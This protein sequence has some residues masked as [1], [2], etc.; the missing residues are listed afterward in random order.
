MSSAEDQP[1]NRPTSDARL[2]PLGYIL[3]IQFHEP[4]K[5]LR[6]KGYEFAAKLSPY[7]DARGAELQDNAWIFSQPLGDSAAGL[8]RLLVQEQM[9]SLEAR[10]PTNPLDWFER[11]YELILDEFRKA[12][13]PTFLIS[14]S[15]MVLGTVSVFG[16]AR[17]FLF[18]HV[19]NI[20]ESKLKPLGRPV[21]IVGI[22][23]GMPPFALQGATQ[24]GGK[25]RKAKIVES[26][27]WAVDVKAESLG[28]DTKK[29]YLEATGQWPLVPKSWDAQA[30]KEAVTRLATVKNYLEDNL[31]PFLTGEPRN[32]GKK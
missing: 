23:F 5:L 16:D 30:T 13:K 3:S 18:E 14:S 8:F 19:A 22:R 12:F 21:H 28:T 24:K 11:R 29:L 17:A 4:I 20:P 9:L 1:T 26:T 27:E 15:A 31:L 6:Q 10:L 7:V 25:K 2:E 32:G